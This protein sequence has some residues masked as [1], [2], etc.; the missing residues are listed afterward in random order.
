MVKNLPINDFD[1]ELFTVLMEECGEAIVAVS[2][3]LR[4]GL[5]NRHPDGDP[6]NREKLV[7]ELGDIKAIMQILSERDIFAAEEIDRRVAVK[8]RKLDQYMLHDK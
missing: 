7:E 1:R 8:L 3:I 2:K 5:Y 6:E 4:F